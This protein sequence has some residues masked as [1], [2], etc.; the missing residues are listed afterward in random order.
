VQSKLE[1]KPD[2]PVLLYLQAD[3]LAQRSAD[4]SG[5]DFQLAMSSAQKAVRLQ[6]TLGAARGVLAKLHMQAGQYPE[7]VEQCRQAL[8]SDPKDQAALYR[9]IQALRKTGQQDEIPELLKKL[10]QLREEA[11]QE[12]RERYRYKLIEDAPAGRSAP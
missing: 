6:P 11:T 7:A 3:L 12:E 5:P 8:K 1:R 10:A 9:L 2:D 4:A